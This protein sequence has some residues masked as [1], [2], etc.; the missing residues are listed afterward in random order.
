[1]SV[2]AYGTPEYAALLAEAQQRQREMNAMGVSPSQYFWMEEAQ[3]LDAAKRRSQTMP[4]AGGGSAAAQPGSMGYDVAKLAEAE[5]RARAAQAQAQGGG[6]ATQTQGGDGALGDGVY[7]DNGNYYDPGIML[8]GNVYGGYGG[9]MGV[10]DKD[11]NVHPLVSFSSTYPIVLNGGRRQ[12]IYPEQYAYE[13]RRML[14]MSKPWVIPTE[15]EAYMRGET[16]RASGGGGGGVRRGGG[17]GG[18]AVAAPKQPAPAAQP[19]APA[20]QPTADLGYDV[21]DLKAAEAKA[22]VGLPYEPAPAEYYPGTNFTYNDMVDI[23]TE[24]AKTVAKANMIGP[25]GLEINPYSEPNIR[26]QITQQMQQARAM[27]QGR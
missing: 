4:Y 12:R 2:P 1:M 14:E 26:S 7:V 3:A 17:G 20:A 25:D 5:Q 15:L 11:G 9:P 22:G 18:G 24:Q 13:M 8:R 6:A 23:L 16:P 10:R 19:P 21:G 27:G